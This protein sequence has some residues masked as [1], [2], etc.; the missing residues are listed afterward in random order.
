MSSGPVAFSAQDFAWS[1]A[2][3]GNTVAGMVAYREGPVRFT[4]AGS[5]VVLTP[6]TAWSRRR[7]AVLYGSPDR[8]AVP[9]DEVRARTPS[10]PP[11]DAGP[12]V[13][14]TTCDDAGRFSLSGLPD[15]GWFVITIARPV[16]Q[17][18]GSSVALMRR[19]VTRGGK[20]QTVAL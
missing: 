8:A 11:G 10:A 5:S 12:F 18:Q 3:G 20:P 6:E 1:K 17:S 19:V 7:M 4:C 2:A 16:G 14:R 9:T 13:R 15:G